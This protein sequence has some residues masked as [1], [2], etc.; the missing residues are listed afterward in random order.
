[1]ED[2]LKNIRYFL[3][4]A[5]G[6]LWSVFQ[7]YAA[8]NVLLDTM[9]LRGTHVAFALALAFLL[10]PSFK[11]KPLHSF[12]IDL[13]LALLGIFVGLHAAIDFQR[14]VERIMSIDPMT[15]ADMVLGIIAIPLILEATRRA[16]MAALAVFAAIFIAYA[17]TGPY[18]IGGLKHSG[19]TI[20][21]W[22]E[23]LYLSTEGIFGVPTG[24]SSTYVYLFILFVAFLQS[25][26]VGQ[27]YLD[28]AFAV[29]GRARGGAAKAA[30]VA[31]SFFGT[32]SGSAVANT[33]GT[34]SFLS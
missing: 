19:A 27:F 29:T 8:W 30:V 1:M 3:A 25:T 17:L 21:E 34:G 7:L 32:I 5:L 4:G 13:A 26:N 28:L 24:V 10:N 31:S 22:V 12:V 16:V 9:I 2:K 23:Y 11:S 14:I 20:G 33:V 15:T 6:I 18:L